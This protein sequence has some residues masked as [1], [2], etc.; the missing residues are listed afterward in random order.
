MNVICLK[1]IHM[2]K[3]FVEKL[4]KF[5]ILNEFND[6]E[7]LNVFP[8]N[9]FWSLSVILKFMPLKQSEV[10]GEMF[11]LS[12]HAYGIFLGLLINI[13]M[14]QKINHKI[15]NDYLE[16]NIIWTCC[17]FA[18]LNDQKLTKPKLMIT[19]N[20]KYPMSFL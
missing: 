6:F 1:T 7:P 9:G 10:C 5:P 11:A 14:S 2:S 15:R 8:I 4:K 20:W 13:L 17:S 16:W 19:L 12:T 3:D 18:S